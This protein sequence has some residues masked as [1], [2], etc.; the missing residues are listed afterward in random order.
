[1]GSDGKHTKKQIGHKFNAEETK[2]MLRV[3]SM[4]IYKLHW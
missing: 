2:I 3:S 4:N 1:M